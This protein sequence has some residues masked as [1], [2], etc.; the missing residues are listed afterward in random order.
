MR[1]RDFIVIGAAGLAAG[2]AWARQGRSIEVPIRLENGRVLVDVM[3]NGE[4][5]A[6][7]VIDTGGSVSGMKS[8]WSE[9]LGVRPSR[10]VMLNGK[11]FPLYEVRDVV[12]GGVIRQPSVALFGLEEGTTLGAEGLLAAGTVTAMDASLEYE[13]GVWSVYPD[14]MPPLDGYERLPSEMKAYSEGASMIP[15]A[16]VAVN[17]RVMRALWDTGAPRP[18]TVHY[19]VARG[20]GLLDPSIPYAPI[21]FA[22]IQGVAP[23]TGRMVRVERIT[24]GSNDYSDMLLAIYPPSIPRRYHALLGLPIMRTLDT[25]FDRSSRTFS[26][27]R[28][29]LEPDRAPK[30]PLSGIWLNDRRGQARVD[31]VGLNS[32]AAEAGVQVGDLL[33]GASLQEGVTLLAGD[34]GEARE[35]RLNRDGRSLTVRFDLRAYL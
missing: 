21:G 29:G 8:G 2:P 9:R 3:L 19:E 18:L 4:G 30:Y 7:F 31:A 27:R 6:P 33:E 13:R 34:E 25:A 16:D 28:N 26:V 12:F 32:P 11:R 15:H 35:L 10:H 22:G 1:R 24:I 20:L 14:G 23:D 17:G 5:P